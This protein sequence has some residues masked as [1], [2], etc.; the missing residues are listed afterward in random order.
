MLCQT[1]MILYITPLNAKLNP[2]YH[3]LTLLG[4]HYILHLSRIRVNTCSVH[5]LL[6]CT[7][8]NKCKLFHK[9]SYCYMLRQY[10][11]ILRDFVINTLP[12]YTSIS[13]AAVGN[14]I[15][16]IVNNE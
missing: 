9:L 13:N 6:F 10:C 1:M 16:T 8:N 11:V 3:L 12:S 2:I 4:A 14:I 7:I 5:L 15:Y